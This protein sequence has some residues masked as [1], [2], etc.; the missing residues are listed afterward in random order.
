MRNPWSVVA[1]VM[2]AVAS[3]VACEPAAANST[4]R[5]V[6]TARELELAGYAKVLCSA[7]FLSGRDIAEAAKNSGDVLMP[8]GRD[9]VTWHV[10]R[11]QRLVRLTVDGISREARF[12]GDQGCIVQPQEKPG[13]SFTPIRV[14]TTLPEAMSQPWPMGESLTATLFALLVKDGTYTLEQPAPIPA[15]GAPGDPRSAI[16]NIDLLRMSSG[17]RFIAPR[18]PDYTPDKGYP[19]HLYIYTGGVD[20]FEYS[21]NQPLQFPV[22][23]TGRYRNSDPLTVGY[24]IKQAVTKRGDEY[25]T[26]PQRALFDRIGI[27]RFILETDPYGNFLM[28]GYNYGTARDWARVGLLHLQDGVWQGQ[29]VLPEGWAKFV[30]TPAPA[31]S[32]RFRYGGFFWLN[33]GGAFNLPKDAYYAAGAGG[34]LAFIVPSKHLVVVRLGHTTGW[35]ARSRALN[36]AL[37]RLTDAIKS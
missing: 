5:P 18:D 20:V 3:V 23:R 1:V 19:D 36:D 31:W 35:G 33:D 34:Q 27:R 6:S 24:L 29:R 10:D 9:K 2:L 12:H 28:S 32:G 17:L 26:W 16:R 15:W 25:L 4:Y 8:A 22:G 13:I 11:E 37:A 14:K 21:I 30:S 7:V